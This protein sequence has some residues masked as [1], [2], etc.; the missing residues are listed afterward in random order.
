M[1]GLWQKP[2]HLPPHSFVVAEVFYWDVFITVLLGYR[3][4]GLS[5]ARCASSLKRFLHET[6]QYLHVPRLAPVQRGIASVA[7]EREWG[8]M[9]LGVLL[10]PVCNWP[11]EGG[12]NRV[13]D[14]SEEPGAQVSRAKRRNSR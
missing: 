1:N 13:S 2:I 6:G 8:A 3:G 11:A 14:K 5:V 12:K 4:C 7:L 9:D 10:F